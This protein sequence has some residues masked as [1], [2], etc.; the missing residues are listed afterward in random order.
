[1]TAR[2]GGAAALT[3]PPR[4]KWASVAYV[5]VLCEWHNFICHLET[6]S[7]YSKKAASD[8]LTLFYEVV[9]QQTRPQVSIEKKGSVGGDSERTT[10]HTLLSSL[11]LLLMTRLPPRKSLFPLM[12]KQCASASRAA[13]RWD[14]KDSACLTSFETGHIQLSHSTFNRPPLTVMFLF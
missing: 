8:A 7:S 3:R 2:S 5:S 4:Q 12:R 13:S 1:M 14:P 11:V 9:N 6:L 10:G